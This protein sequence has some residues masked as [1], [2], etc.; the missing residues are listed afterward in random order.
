MN[1]RQ[2]E[3][4]QD[5]VLDLKVISDD[6]KNVIFTTSKYNMVITGLS[7]RLR[8]AVRKTYY[9]RREGFATV[10]VKVYKDLND[11]WETGVRFRYKTQITVPIIS[12][13]INTCVERM[14]RQPVI[15]PMSYKGIKTE[16]IWKPAYPR[17]SEDLRGY[18]GSL[19]P[20]LGLDINM[21]GLS[22]FSV[23]K[24]RVKT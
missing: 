9:E 10:A 2:I 15:S 17:S 21:A 6:R 20:T 13:Y 1:L 22:T 24:G 8:N 12:D 18:A 7:K 3:I 4:D 19:C 11:V 14:L 5:R 23:K 16:L